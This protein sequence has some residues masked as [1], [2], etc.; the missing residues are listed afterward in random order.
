MQGKAERDPNAGLV[1]VPIV[2]LI[3]RM[4]Q[5]TTAPFFTVFYQNHLETLAEPGEAAV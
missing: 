4:M 1:C 5:F 3:T 2:K